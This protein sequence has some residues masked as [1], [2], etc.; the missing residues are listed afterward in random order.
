M[1]IDSHFF[2]HGQYYGSQSRMGDDSSLKILV[3][4]KEVN[5]VVYIPT[6]Y[7]KKY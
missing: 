7:N 2:S 4:A 1:Y 3:V 5:G 6:M